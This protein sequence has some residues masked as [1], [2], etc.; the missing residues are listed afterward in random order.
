MKKKKQIQ[1]SQPISPKKYIMQKGRS[2]PI[3]SC[4]I[5]EDWEKVGETPVIVARRHASGKFT[6][7]LY[8]IDTFCVGLKDS[9]Y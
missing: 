3:D 9:F 6:I 5:L 8:L 4:W 7:G 2:L 1:Q